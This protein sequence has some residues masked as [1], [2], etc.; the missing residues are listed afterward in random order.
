MSRPLHFFGGLGAL[1]SCGK[2]D[3]S[4]LLAMKVL[5]PHQNVMDQHGPM[6]VIGAVLIWPPADACIGMLGEL[7][8]RHYSPASIQRLTPSTAW[9]VWLR[10]RAKLLSEER[11]AVLKQGLGTKG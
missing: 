6:F 11:K 2:H 4:Y 3:L 7:Q 5:E 1:G 8:V 10:R 9:C